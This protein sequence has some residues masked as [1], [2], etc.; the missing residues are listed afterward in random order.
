MEEK[1]IGNYS[2][3]GFPDDLGVKNVHGRLGAAL[4]PQAFLDAFGKLTGSPNLKDFC[5][6]TVLVEMGTELEANY[7]RAAQA[8]AKCLAPQRLIVIG[9]GHDYAYPWIKGMRELHRLKAPEL[10]CINIDAHF[11]LR[12][13]LPVMTSGSPFRRLLDEGVLSAASLIEFGIQQ[14][15]NS[16]ELWN[17]VAQKKIK[18]IPL[19][20]LR[21]GKAVPAFKKSL[22]ALKK[23]CKKIVLSLD[24]DALSFAYCPGVSAPQA[25]G[26]TASDVFEMLEIAG[27]E[28]KVISLGIFEL[29]PPQD[30]Q[31]YTARL[32]AQGVWHFLANKVK[33]K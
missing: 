10:G 3:V 12:S 28:A 2:I 11:D 33:I 7:V 26:F 29:S 9:G 4:G 5:S 14:H 17:Y 30:V 22:M 32:A 31:N 23:S 15:C 27:N 8:V 18:V 1:S 20:R 16:E 24:L 25:E 21:H 19:N 13:P 6:E